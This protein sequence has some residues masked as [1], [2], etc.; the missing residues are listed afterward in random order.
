[1]YITGT[2]SMSS[3]APFLIVAT[4][5]SVLHLAELGTWLCPLKL[6]LVDLQ[7]L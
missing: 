6:P 2:V 7:Q 3:L 1:M 4:T 5:F